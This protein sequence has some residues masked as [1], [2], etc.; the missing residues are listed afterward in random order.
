MYAEYELLICSTRMSRVAFD[1]AFL[2]RNLEFLNKA[3]Y[4]SN[5]FNNAFRAIS[6]HLKANEG[7]VLSNYSSE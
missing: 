1:N 2:Q 6:C 4:P 3:F 5:G 7:D